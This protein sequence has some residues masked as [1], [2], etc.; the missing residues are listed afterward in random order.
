MHP[1]NLKYSEYLT[2]LTI[3][4]LEAFYPFTNEELIKFQTVLNFRED[5]LI[6]NSKISWNADLF[7]TIKDRIDFSTLYR[8]T[9]LVIDYNF[10]KKFENYFDFSALPYFKNL[11]YSEDIIKA[12]DSKLDWTTLLINNDGF[13]TIE[14]I[15]KYK[16]KINW[17][18]LS[19][20]LKYPIDESFLD[21]FA[22]YINWDK[23]SYNS[24]L[25]MDVALLE[26]YQENFNFRHLSWNPAA[27]ALILNYPRS[28]RWDW[29]LVLR[30]QGI[31][32]NEENLDILVRNHIRKNQW[33]PFFKNKPVEIAT[34]AARIHIISHLIKFRQT[35]ADFLFNEKFKDLYIWDLISEASSTLPKHFVLD[36]FSKFKT[37][38]SE[39]VN[40]NGKYFNAELIKKNIEK[41]DLKRWEFYKL[42]ITLDIVQEITEKID[43]LWLSSNESIEWNA[44]FIYN[45]RD[46]LHFYRLCENKKIY[47]KLLGDWSRED[48]L[49]FLDK[50]C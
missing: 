45:N 8:A 1:S 7:D 34:R 32:I 27:A 33:H 6:K 20:S 24:N 11:T 31:E 38:G 22:D 36:N 26:K 35:G 43:F 23:L 29:H 49:S 21:E 44:D 15:R 10:L 48:V 47:D 17:D 12:F 4:L 25:K 18:K 19:G 13:N 9:N 39:F 41:F 40:K 2:D 30:N 14:N 3:G 5:R 37:L 28:S 50:Q 42:N 16:D 46:R